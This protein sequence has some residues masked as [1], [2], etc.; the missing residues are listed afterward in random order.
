MVLNPNFFGLSIAFVAFA[1]LDLERGA[2]VEADR[3]TGV[4]ERDL[5]EGIV[6]LPIP[7][8]LDFGLISDYSVMES[9]FCDY[10]CHPPTGGSSACLVS[11]FCSV[12]P[13]LSV[14]TSNNQV[15][16]FHE[17]GSADDSAVVSTDSKPSAMKWRPRQKVLA[18]GQVCAWFCGLEGVGD[19]L[20]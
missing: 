17:E 1:G 8:L 12:E 19:E 5:E 18:V 13:I 11:A 10:R 20:F 3:F 16:F 4:L 9:L 7:D 15:V 14:G 6:L 2:D